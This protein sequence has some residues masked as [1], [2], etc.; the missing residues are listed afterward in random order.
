[1][2]FDILSLIENIVLVTIGAHF[3][4]EAEEFFKY[5]FFCGMVVVLHLMGL[6]L[7][8]IF[9]RYH[10]PWMSLSATKKALGLSLNI[11]FVILGLVALGSLPALGYHLSHD[12][13]KTSTTSI[14]LYILTVFITMFVSKNLIICVDCFKQ[15]FF[16]KVLLL[17]VHSQPKL[18]RC[19]KGK[20]QRKRDLENQIETIP[21]EIF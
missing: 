7:K 9:Y 6:L 13:E 16:S 11:T 19:C 14:V 3:V 5:G 12:L 17:V 8:A 20:K 21:L 18:P 10:H 4:S 15:F 2:L 1:M